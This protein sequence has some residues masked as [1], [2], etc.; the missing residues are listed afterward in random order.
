MAHNLAYFWSENIS[1]PM[2]VRGQDIKKLSMQS[3]N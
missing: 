1:C 2:Y 3:F